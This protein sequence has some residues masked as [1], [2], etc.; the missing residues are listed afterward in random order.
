MPRK[1][2][3]H[4]RAVRERVEACCP[5]V[6]WV[7]IDGCAEREVAR[8][9]DENALFFSTQDGE[10]FGLPA[11]EAMARGA[12]VTGY[13]GTGGF[14]APYATPRNGFWAPDR[15][16][17]SAVQ[18]VLAAV[19]LARRRGPALDSVLTAGRE[20]L[21]GF[22]EER[23]LAAIGEVL[24]SVNSGEFPLRSQPRLGLRG[25]F[26]AWR[27]LLRA[28]VILRRSRQCAESKRS[29]AIR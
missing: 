15:S 8:R 11:I 26:Q 19:D 10:G 29:A 7:E 17:R 21:T 4:V 2:P 28:P 16:P 6:P 1:L 12:L 9:L 23:A 13:R 14:P 24:R 5:Q 22:T 25:H 27:C 20:T 3:D 18:R